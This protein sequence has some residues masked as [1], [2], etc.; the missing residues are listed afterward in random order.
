MEN[1]Q[2]YTPTKIIFGRG[3]EEQ[4]GQLAAEQGCKKVLVHYGGGSVVRSGLLERIYR[5]LDAAGISYVSLGGVVP[6]PRLSLVYEGIRLARKEQ[7]DFILPVGGGSV[8]DSAKAIGYGVA[9]EGDVWDFYEKRRT[10][11]ACL[12]IGV[13]LTIAAAGSEMSDSS[14][15][16]KEE[17]WLKRGYSSNYARARFAVMNPELTMT[18]PKYQTASGCVDI[19]MH[20]MERYFNHSENMEMTDGISEHLLRTVMK[21]AKI[22]MN[23][24]DNYQA[25]AEVMWAGSLSHN[26]L[27]GC[28]T[29]G[30]DWASHQ[31]EHELGGMFDV[32]HGAGLAAV[33]GSWA[34]YVM[35]AAP[36]RF[37]KFA[38]NVMGVEP[39]A[40]K[41]KT[42]QKGIEAM[43]D[44]YR[45]LDMP[46]CIGD[47]GIE[48]AEEQMRELAEKCSHF[49]KRT[50]GC[51]KKLDQEDMY[52]IYKEARGRK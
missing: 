31:L 30:G 40:E 32:A 27:T 50:I 43:E 41:L 15:I 52:R 4:T 23:E 42:A 13:V 49:G 37:A 21:N 11:K 47:M 48:L 2:Y 25:R 38:V 9:N 51:I 46:V 17:G 19:M 16:T 29:G 35:D 5:S 44:F 36:E 8:I 39:E 12:P 7:V 34:R 14:V 20:T 18:L 24:P 28:G 26:G 22:L 33:W 3:A 10:A 1:F 45:A 6:N